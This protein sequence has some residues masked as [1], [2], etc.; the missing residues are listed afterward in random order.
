MPQVEPHPSTF[1][2]TI[3]LGRGLRNT[4]G[5]RVELNAVRPAESLR[6]RMVKHSGAEAWLSPH[7]WVDDRRSKTAWAHS[8]AIAVDLD[9][10]APGASHSAPSSEARSALDSSM[11]ILAHGLGGAL[12]AHATP[13]GHRLWI[14][15]AAP[16]SEHSLYERACAGVTFAVERWL[17]TSAL[18]G[19]KSRSETAVAG[20]VIDRPALGDR[21]RLLW[22]PRAHAP[23]EVESRNARV[24]VYGLS[25]ITAE[26]IASHAAIHEPARQASATHRPNLIKARP[27]AEGSRNTTLTS[28]AGS[29]RR[30]GLSEDAMS[31]ALAAENAARCVPPLTDTEVAG[32]ARSVGRYR[33]ADEAS[34]EAGPAWT[35]SR[36]AEQVVVDHGADIR[37]CGPWGKWLVWNGCRWLV[38]VSG[39]IARLVK[40]T[41]RRLHIEALGNEDRAKVFRSAERRA[42]RDNV[43]ILASREA[44]VQIT[45]EILDA[46]SWLLN[47]RN[48]TIDLRSGELHAHRRED[49]LTKL[50]PV[51]YD[52]SAKAPIWDEFISRIFDGNNGVADF[53]QRAVGYSLSGDVS[54]QV[55]FM[56]WGTGANG[57]S[58]LLETLAAMLGDYAMPG[59]DDLLL[60]AR[61][62]R[63]PT[64]VADLF[65]R[66]IVV[67]QETQAGGRFDEA[68]VKR[69]TGGDRVKARRMRE[70]FWE[71]PPTHKL[72][73]GT[74]HRPQIRGT[75][76]AIWR[77][78]RLI[79]FTVTIPSSERDRKLPLKLRSELPAILAWAVRGCQA[80]QRS[81]L[82]P[83]AEV[84]AATNAYRHAEDRFASFLAECCVTGEQHRVEFARLYLAFREWAERNREFV[85]SATAFGCALME[86]GF[87]P[88][89]RGHTK[90]KIR[91]GICLLEDVRVGAGEPAGSSPRARM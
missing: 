34:G 51:D 26:A 42:T 15:L 28:I 88:G 48:G 12:L 29:M 43:Q 21:A 49:Q 19:E 63:H 81:G 8:S 82:A 20:Y 33:P 74:N 13:R 84:I 83:P 16:I 70:D 65:G 37:F 4:R 53:V 78:I 72:W 58:T 57:K 68:R 39:E 55:I 38:D 66:R 90:T 67:C 36:I 85:M 41:I 27:I 2:L 10:Y 23:G 61:N 25:P 71:F 9:Y 89:I 56:A 17:A 31:A 75:D 32:I 86:R 87:E 64:E 62:Q 54:E 73:M 11:A 77:R 24:E 52:P 35:E 14:L 79:P 30:R 3:T 69:L 40:S 80:W 91:K 1:P 45:P 59:A 46:D 44:G 7:V 60:A 76:L 50:A 47:C 5:L 18:L 22:G 6:D